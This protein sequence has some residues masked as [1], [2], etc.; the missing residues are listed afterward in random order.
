[1][2]KMKQITRHGVYGILLKEGCVLLTQKKS[3]PY[4]GLWGLP[5]G[6]FE[7]GETPEEAL[8]RELLEETALSAGLIEFSTTATAHGIY[9]HTE[10]PYAFYQVGL[11]YNVLSW[12]YRPDL[13]PQEEMR[14]LPLTNIVLNELTPFAKQALYD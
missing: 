11:I 13:V 4:K 14:W 5:G 1:M 12:T 2:T 8:K 10:E 3:G 6:G 7:F 9:D